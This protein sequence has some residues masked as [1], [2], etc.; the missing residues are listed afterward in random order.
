MNPIGLFKTQLEQH[1]ITRIRLE[2]LRT[3]QVPI[4]YTF[5]QMIFIN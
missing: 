4:N 1:G 5:Q 2:H 3:I